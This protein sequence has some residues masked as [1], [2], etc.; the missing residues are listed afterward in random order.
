MELVKKFLPVFTEY[1]EESYFEGNPM[2]LYDPVNY[3]M[4][5]GGKRLR[6]VLV[7]AACELF[8]EKY[9][10]ALPAALA[11]EV[12]HNFSL[13]H[14]DIMDDAPLRR[15]KSTVHV[16]YDTNSAILSGDVMLILAYQ[17]LCKT[18]N[19]ALIPRLMNLFNST[20]VKVC[21]GQ[22]A[23]MNFEST[24]DVTID[25]YLKMIEYKTAA[26]LQGSLE[27]G[28]VIA[29]ASEE[30][31]RELSEFGKKIGIAFQLQD[32]FLDTFGNA[33]KFG[34][35]P[36]GDIIQNKK[37]FLILKALEKAPENQREELLSLMNDTKME[38][39]EK[40]SKVTGILEELNVPRLTKDLIGVYKEQAIKHLNRISVS[41]NAKKGFLEFAN[42]IID[43]ES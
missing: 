2:E 10:K 18:E 15:G 13:V 24:N 34:K 1:L 39:A 22:Q 36:G 30:D 28:A 31:I 26:L 17:C 43:R 12:F 35:Q 37:T 9:E 6:P 19:S 11:V 33:E 23:D 3:I 4:G 21:E 40:V 27:L 5:I 38:N 32:D 29:R 8:E 7:L 20:A 41:G 16:K 14:D 42:L 25:E